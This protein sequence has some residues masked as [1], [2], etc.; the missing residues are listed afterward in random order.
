MRCL[1][2]GG[3][4]F[5]GSH[6][7]EALLSAG[8]LV[9]VFERPRS[10]TQLHPDVL[11]KL[12]WIEGDFSNPVEVDEAL[13]GCE[14]V[15]HLISTTLPKSSNEN[16]VYDV[17]SN[18]VSTL[19]MLELACKWGV[20]KVIFTS[21][22][23]TVYGAPK[24]VPIAEEHATN[25]MSSYGICKL[26]IEK[27]LALFHEL[28]GLDFTVLRLSNPY[29]ERQRVDASQG[30]V[31][32]FLHKAMTHQ[33]IEIWGDGTVIRDYLYI[34]DLIRAMLKSID[35]SGQ[36]KLFNIGSSAGKSLN[37][38]LDVIE[39]VVSQPVQRIY[40]PSRVFDVPANVLDIRIADEYLD[41]R[42]EVSFESGIERFY[43]YLADKTI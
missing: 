33:P 13:R 6:L 24:Q 18:L 8:Y 38:I 26:A 22:G 11:A 2:F 43:A 39:R 27:Y 23:G 37:N 28:H 41:W 34:G 16:P 10:K 1:I 7:A 32:V 36:V 21:S 19:K 29:G 31:A 3:G 25:P 42:P 9:R 40:Q 14:I 15:F 4:G 30:A 20:R 12:E 35:Y 17:E 5:I